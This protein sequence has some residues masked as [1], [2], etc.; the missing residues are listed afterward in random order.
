MDKTQELFVLRLGTTK[1]ARSLQYNK[2]D[3]LPIILM[4][5]QA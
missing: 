1:R 5:L 2:R 4:R 3:V